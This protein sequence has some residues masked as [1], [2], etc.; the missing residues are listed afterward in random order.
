MAEDIVEA[1]N[2]E[3]VTTGLAEGIEQTESTMPS[4]SCLNFFSYLFYLIDI[5]EYTYK[6][7]IF[8][9]FS[10]YTSRINK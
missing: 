1:Q 9:I 4:M 7:L 5:Q 3:D 2:F 10:S 6:V 8:V